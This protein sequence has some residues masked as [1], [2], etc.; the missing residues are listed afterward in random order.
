LS[1]APFHFIH[2]LF[3]KSSAPSRN[4]AIF[5]L[6]E[7]IKAWRRADQKMG[8]RIAN[9]EFD[10]L[11][12]LLPLP[13]TDDERMGGFI[14]AVLFYGF[15]DDGRGNA[16]AVLSGKF[17]WEYALKDRKGKTWRCEYVDFD[18]PQDIR[19]R[20]EAPARPQGFYY[21]KIRFD[22]KS[23]A[24]TVSQVRKSLTTD[25]GWG[26]EGFQFLAIT[27]PHFAELMN[28]R[29]IPFLA[30]ADYDVAPYG[31]NDF[32]DAPQLFCSNSKL[33]LGIGNVDRNYPLFGIPTLRF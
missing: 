18:K 21:A 26:P 24:M 4:T 28:E 11:S 29:K 23:K 7:H 14:G 12:V 20:P 16:D 3:F 8:W 13:L 1:T 30:L 9:G 6:K 17:A 22:E 27:H 32:F 2:N 25:T 33:G 15:G 10:K 19:L 31:F 5:P